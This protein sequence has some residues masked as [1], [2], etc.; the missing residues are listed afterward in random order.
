MTHYRAKFLFLTFAGII[1]YAGATER[2]EAQQFDPF[3]SVEFR[4][5]PEYAAPPIRVGSFDVYPQIALEGEYI[6]NVFASEVLNVSDYRVSI[7]PTVAI[8]N[9]RPDRTLSLDLATGYETYL[10]KT[11]EDRFRLDARAR[12]RFGLGTQTRPFFGADIGYNDV[13]GGERIADFRDT[14]QPVKLKTY[15][16]NAGLDREFGPLTATVEGSYKKTDFDGSILIDNV[17]VNGSLRNFDV[18]TGRMRLAYS[19]NPAQR[20]YVEGSLNKRDYADVG[21][22]GSVPN[23]LIT[24]RP[25]NGFTIRAGYARQL[26]ELLLLDISVGYLNQDFGDPA[27]PTLSTVSYLANIF[28]SPTP[29]TRVKLQAA[30][31]IDETV[32]PFFNGLLRTEFAAS[33]EH[34]LLRNL[35]LS[36]SGR[37]TLIDA[38]RTAPDNKE[39]SMS[40]TARYLLSRH[41]SVRFRTEYFERKSIFPGSQTRALIGIAYDF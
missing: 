12:A 20:F 4:P 36:A 31:S 19:R 24:N 2:A 9:L 7:N 39:L 25:S 18:I 8:R 6:D 11:V 21:N 3:G 37:Y 26:S 29:L 28:Y 38:G 22:V 33:I 13:S 34:E 23:G 32:N 15:G 5:R 35:I 14:A 30:R 41:W 40:A 17:Q 1:A 27:T 16:A 10:D